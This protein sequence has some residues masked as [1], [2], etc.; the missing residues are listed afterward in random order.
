MYYLTI[1]P[2]AR[3]FNGYGIKPQNCEPK[4]PVFLKSSL[5]HIFYTWQ[6]AAKCTY[7]IPNTAVD[8]RDNSV[9]SA[10]VNDPKGQGPFQ[11]P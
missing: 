10:R 3:G 2:K 5:S 7:C 9:S 8:S 1:T 6:E 4:P 11:I